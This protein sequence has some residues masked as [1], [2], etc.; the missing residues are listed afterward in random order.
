MSVLH[1]FPYLVLSGTSNPSTMRRLSSHAVHCHCEQ[2]SRYR[3]QVVREFKKLAAVD[4]RLYPRPVSTNAAH[5]N[6]GDRLQVWL[7]VFGSNTTP[8][9]QWL[10]NGSAS[11]PAVIIPLGALE[12][13]DNPPSART[14]TLVGIYEFRNLQPDTIYHISV[15]ADGQHASLQVR[16][17][18]TQLSLDGT[19]QFNVLLV[20]CY[21]QP[22]DR[23]SLV[24]A[25]AGQL[26]GNKAPHLTLLLGDQVYLDL[27]TLK[28][29]KDDIA[30]LAEQFENSYIRNWQGPGG[31]R[32][33]LSSSP[34]IHIPDDH[35]YWNNA[36]H[37]SPV[38]GNSRTEGGRHRW[39]LAA[40]ML[41]RAFQLPA[42]LQPGDPFIID[43]PPL[44]FFLADSRSRRTEFSPDEQGK[45]RAE[46]MGSTARKMLNDWC[47]RLV[48][49]KLFGV[50]ATGQSLYDEP[51]GSWKG[52][53]ADYTLANYG[54]YEEII[55]KLA[56]VSDRGQPLVFLT[57]DVHWGR[58]TTINDVKTGRPAMYE[59]ISSPSAL[60]ETV[61]YDGL[62]RAIGT[63]SGW[64]GSADPWPR[65]SDPSKP[66]DFLATQVLGKRYVTGSDSRTNGVY[67]HKGDQL[68]LLSFTR[69]GYGL[70]LTVTYYPVHAD[71]AIR[72]PSKK[73]LIQL[74]PL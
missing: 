58:V 59:V 47:D 45:P 12:T 18:P 38:V 31:L 61:G 10:L 73:I 3:I 17:L 21:Y 70:D 52:S 48:Q 35:E 42:P 55:A 28:D 8:S 14:R 11:G 7:G 6:A 16:T 22:E 69:A 74:R 5:Q 30:W 24:S 68:T 2:G 20:S 64:F 65:H 29:F 71:T 40:E 66:P 37:Y 9:L 32:T 56:S 43:V 41:Y 36:P 50:F 63:L 23:N 51:A 13:E 19:Q 25:V 44:S 60:V 57:G 49:D 15:Q 1:A 27:P 72:Q 54:D 33:I 39:R 53:I 67:G 4:I 46:A 26:N 62:K 34:C